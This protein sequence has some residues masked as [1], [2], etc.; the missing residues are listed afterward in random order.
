M[1]SCEQGLSLQ[2]LC[3]ESYNV[4]NR[5]M[6]INIGALNVI[7]TCGGGVC[8]RRAVPTAYGWRAMSDEYVQTVSTHAHA[9]QRLD[10]PDLVLQNLYRSPL[11]YGCA[12][13][14]R[15]SFLLFFGQ[16]RAGQLDCNGFASSDCMSA[17]VVLP[18]AWFACSAHD[19]ELGVFISPVWAYSL[20]SCTFPEH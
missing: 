1:A 9:S 15:H 17:C 20:L 16:P 11:I 8:L 13:A 4:L 14:L 3:D 19:L 10:V 5:Y 12:W 2:H 6:A 18:F 7:A